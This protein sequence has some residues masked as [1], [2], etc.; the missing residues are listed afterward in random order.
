MGA[1]GEN[2]KGGTKSVEVG[3]KVMMEKYLLIDNVGNLIPQ[4]ENLPTSVKYVPLH[5][6]RL[7]L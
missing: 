3:G 7:H 6:A 4:K 2:V 5:S 1:S